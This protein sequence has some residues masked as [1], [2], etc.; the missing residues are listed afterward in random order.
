MS[1]LKYWFVKIRNKE[2]PDVKYR[3]MIIE[4]KCERS[5]LFLL[6]TKWKETREY[7]EDKIL[8]NKESR[9]EIVK[10]IEIS[11]EKFDRLSRLEK[12]RK[13]KE[14]QEWLANGGKEKAMKKLL[15]LVSLS[16]FI[17]EDYYIK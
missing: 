5:A 3:G 9:I 11:K 14:Y 16:T 10:F 7:Y 8:H 6:S 17:K 15:S 13:E 1:K 2:K 4:A 12:K